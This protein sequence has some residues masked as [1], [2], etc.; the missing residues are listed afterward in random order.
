[1]D[2]PAQSLSL[3]LTPTPSLSP[4]PEHCPCTSLPLS[5]AQTLDVS[6]TMQPHP[7]LCS[8]VNPGSDIAGGAG[9]AVSPTLPQGT[10]SKTWKWL[11]LKLEAAS[12]HP[13]C[14]RGPRASLAPHQGQASALT[15]APCPAPLPAG[16]SHTDFHLTVAV[17][18]ARATSALRMKRFF[19]STM[20]HILSRQ[21]VT[22]HISNC[23]FP[24]I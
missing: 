24:S 5:S 21:T 19:T 7:R 11:R 18:V 1:M 13:S 10:L 8:A 14:F 3:V 2:C 9:Q 12:D 15:S 23:S 4:F 20:T 22:P 17:A 16:V 6:R